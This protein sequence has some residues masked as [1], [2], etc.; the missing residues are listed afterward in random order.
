MPTA[1]VH[2][3][4]HPRPGTALR[5]SREFTCDCEDLE[6]PR[7]V[8]KED[9]SIT[10]ALLQ[11]SAKLVLVPH[12]RNRQDSLAR[13]VK[14]APKEMHP[15]SASEA[16]KLLESAG[17]DRLEALYVLAIHTGMR[18]GELLGLK[19]EDV[20]F[21]GQ[22]IRVRQT[23]TR[24][25]TGYVLGEPK[26][27]NSRRTVRLTQRAV[28]ALRSH[29][30]RQAEEEAKGWCP[31][32]GSR[33]RFRRR[34]RRHYQPFQSPQ[35][36]L[37]AATQESRSTL[38]HLPRPSAHLRLTSLPEKRSPQV[39]SGTSRTRFRSHHPRHL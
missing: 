9:V 15:P 30:V 19:W 5:L 3:Q 31:L 20:D 35:P 8:L 32:P 39:R 2:E 25:G 24:K 16:R 7:S 1:V 14:H 13:Q 18:R 29:R 6:G 12:S 10:R 27:K 34:A 37:R 22:T 4:P 28:E 21:D 23:L 33:P 17:G 11:L 36:F 26:T 38:H